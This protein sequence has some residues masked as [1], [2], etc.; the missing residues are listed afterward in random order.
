MFSQGWLRPT[1]MII[2]GIFLVIGLVM[3]IRVAEHPWSELTVLGIVMVVIGR[4]R[5][6]TLRGK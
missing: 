4:S 5:F 2:G 1:L 6:L 3:S